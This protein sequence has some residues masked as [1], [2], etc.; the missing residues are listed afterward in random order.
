MDADF[1]KYDLK[2]AIK[3]SKNNKSKVK[4]KNMFGLKNEEHIATALQKQE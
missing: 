3:Y 4:S 1:E 2:P